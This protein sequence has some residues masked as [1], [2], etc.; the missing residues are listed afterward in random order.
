[1]LLLTVNV[2][3]EGSILTHKNA[4]SATYSIHCKSNLKNNSRVGRGNVV[5]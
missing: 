2:T 4:Y 5:L 3:V 1:M